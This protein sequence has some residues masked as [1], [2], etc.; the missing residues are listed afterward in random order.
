M[1][2]LLALLQQPTAP[3]TPARPALGTPIAKVLIQPSEAAVQVGDTIRL[4]A[5]AY[6]SA[7]QVVNDIRTTWGISGGYFEGGVD[8][9]GLVTGGS[10]GTLNVS[11]V[12]RPVRGGRSA[13][14]FG[15]GHGA[16][17]TRRAC[18]R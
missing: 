3:A 11:A 13:Y 1:F 17:S 9:T 14:A 5:V 7:G 18:G 6:D 8:S 12:V 2:L 16:S 15:A 10:T 4:R